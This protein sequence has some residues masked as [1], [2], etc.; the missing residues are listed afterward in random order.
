[1]RSLV[2]HRPSPGN[3]DRWFDALFQ[4]WPRLSAN[5]APPVDI[6]QDSDGYRV[7]VELPG[8]KKK[9]FSVDVDNNLLTVASARE[10][11]HDSESSGYI[12]RE[13]RV[14]AFKR[15]FMLPQ[16]VDAERI[17]ASYEDGL[18]TVT[19]PQ[20]AKPKPKQIAVKGS[21]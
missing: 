6:R 17:N 20:F 16:D 5:S 15:S 4:D 2:T 3:V 7:E 1:M 11:D 21:G 8:L 9:D 19:V 12:V 18:L 14:G 13:R 10:Q